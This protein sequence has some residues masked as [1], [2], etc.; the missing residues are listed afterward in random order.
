MIE[1]L[2]SRLTSAAHEDIAIQVA[3]LIAGFAEQP[4]DAATGRLRAEAY[5]TALAGEPAWAIEET[6]NSVIRK[7][8]A[9]LD[10]RYAPKPATFGGL[11]RERTRRRREDLDDLRT[12]ITAPVLDATVF[13]RKQFIGDGLSDIRDEI[14]GRHDAASRQAVAARFTEH[15][16][17][18]NERMRIRDCEREGIDPSLGVTPT[19]VRLL[20]D[21]PI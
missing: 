21:K 3:R 2:K 11:V 20:K 6:V 19:L 5:F 15:L 17:N 1:T 7:E 14:A 18:I 10:Y 16:T 8:Y 4:L 12:L 9:S 13:E